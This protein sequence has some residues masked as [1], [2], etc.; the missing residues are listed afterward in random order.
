MLALFPST[1]KKPVVARTVK[2]TEAVNLIH[3]WM[4][5][6]V[7]NLTLDLHTSPS[8]DSNFFMNKYVSKN[9]PITKN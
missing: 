2:I 6:A 3:L 4:Q 9:P 7:Q 5:N 1:C 8:R